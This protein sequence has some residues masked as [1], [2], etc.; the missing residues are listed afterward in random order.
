MIAMDNKKKKAGRP[1]KFPK[2]PDAERSMERFQVSMRPHVF[3]AMERFRREQQFTPERSDMLDKLMEQFLI[4]NGYLPKP[5][6]E[7]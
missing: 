3:A 2:A 6:A 4:E 1:P 7:S 5:D